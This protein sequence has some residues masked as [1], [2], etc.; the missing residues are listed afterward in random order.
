MCGYF[1]LFYSN[2]FLIMFALFGICFGH[3]GWWLSCNEV[4]ACALFNRAPYHSGVSQCVI[5]H[6]TVY[7]TTLYSRWRVI[8]GINE[9]RSKLHNVNSNWNTAEHKWP[10]PHRSREISDIAWACGS[11]VS[12]VSQWP[13]NISSIPKNK[14]GVQQWKVFSS[15]LLASVITDGHAQDSHELR[16]IFAD[17]HIWDQTL[18]SCDIVLW[19]NGSAIPDRGYRMALLEV[20]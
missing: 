18:Y 20:F 13:L 9:A 15:Q 1:I 19:W 2:Y 11:F 5:T 4:I 10:K 12:S 16:I 6:S 17:W 14:A 8:S 3:I 7:C